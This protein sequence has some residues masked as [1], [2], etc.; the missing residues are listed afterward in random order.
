[1]G[2]KK[3]KKTKEAESSQPQPQPKTPRKRG[4]PRKILTRGKDQVQHTKQQLEDFGASSD[5]K[6]ARIG[7]EEGGKVKRKPEVI[8]EQVAMAYR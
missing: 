6:K 8:L 1:M 7:E 5:S 4:R 3:K 2:K